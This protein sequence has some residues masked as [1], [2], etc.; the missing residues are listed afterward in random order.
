MLK[1]KRKNIGLSSS[2][3]RKRKKKIPH[4]LCTYFGIKAPFMS[5]GADH[6]QKPN[7]IAPNNKTVEKKIMH[8]YHL[9]TWTSSLKVVQVSA[10]KLILRM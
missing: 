10:M 6:K 8:P 5:L 2:P 7:L 4:D 9:N 1:Y 3:K